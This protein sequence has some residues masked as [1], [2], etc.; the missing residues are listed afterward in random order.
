[1][2]FGFYLKSNKV[3]EWNDFYVKYTKI[4]KY[5]N[6]IQ[7]DEDAKERLFEELRKVNSFYALLEAKAVDEKGK[8]IKEL[9]NDIPVGLYDEIAEQ[10]VEWNGQLE[11]YKE[12]EETEKEKIE[13]A[14]YDE[15]TEFVAGKIL[16]QETPEFTTNGSDHEESSQL[17]VMRFIAM[18]GAFQ[19]RKKEKHLTE[20][21]HSLVKIKT[22]RDVNSTAIKKLAR[23]LQG[24]QAQQEV[25]NRL[26]NSH[27]YCSPTVER[28]RAGVKKVYKTIFAK[29]N[30]RKAKKV[31]RRI[32]SG[33]ISHDFLYI[34]A[35]F[36]TGINFYIAVGESSKSFFAIFNLFFG[37]ILFGLCLKIFKSFSINYKYIFNFDMSSNL[38]NARYMLIVSIFHTFFTIITR[39]LHYDHLEAFFLLLSVSIFVMPLDFF[40]MN[41]RFYLLAVYGRSIFNPLSTIRFRHFYFIDVAQ[42]FSFSFVNLFGPVSA[43]KRNY[44]A[45]FVALF[46]SIRVLQC[47][48]RYSSSKLVF[49]HL[50]N[51]T[52][53]LIALSA[54]VLAHLSVRHLAVGFKLI[55]TLFALLWDILMDWGIFR[56]NYMYPGYFYVYILI[57]NLIVRFMWLKEF[58]TSIT[59][60]NKKRME[61][62]AGLLE[63]TRRF[64]WTLIRVE[65]EHLNN[66]NELKLNRVLKLTAGELFYKKDGVKKAKVVDESDTGQ[67]TTNT[68]LDLTE[69]TVTDETDHC[70]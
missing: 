68:S 31:F 9:R 16:H 10:T 1:M 56:Q 50:V 13:C 11:E 19:R 41:S 4:G 30:P 23:K 33:I 35:G 61:I 6:S 49:P 36:L 66:C 43:L 40:F 39:L 24:K 48:K 52:K 60:E 2:G 44:L 32:K 26:R 55:S 12:N 22:Y 51:A 64:A 57:F 46:P 37:F 70:N 47:L 21:L 7:Q 58:I 69:S 59:P 15:S 14:A 63:I 54:F 20:F 42:S 5:I 17:S 27:F 65:V 28:I 29:N 8:L 53:Y 38:N 67:M 45:F 62:V 18:P 34:L 25:L 3:H